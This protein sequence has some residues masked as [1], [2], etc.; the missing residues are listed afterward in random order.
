MIERERERGIFF[1]SLR[2]ERKINRLYKPHFYNQVEY[3]HR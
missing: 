2:K 3:R 1:A